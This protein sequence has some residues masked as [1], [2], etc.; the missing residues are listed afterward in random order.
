[1]PHVVACVLAETPVK[2]ENMP[3]ATVRQRIMRMACLPVPDKFSYLLDNT[4]IVTFAAFKC[5][6]FQVAPEI[7]L[8]SRELVDI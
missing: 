7:L 6:G 1:L 2:C 5:R 8:G 3:S 4:E